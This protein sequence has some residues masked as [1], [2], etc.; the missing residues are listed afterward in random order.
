VPNLKLLLL[1]L[2]GLVVY[3]IF[4][5]FYS[6]RF[7][8]SNVMETVATQKSSNPINTIVPSAPALISLPTSITGNYIITS[9]FSILSSLTGFFLQ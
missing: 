2:G 7:F 8:G 9:L 1:L 3:D 5:V 4:W 6:S